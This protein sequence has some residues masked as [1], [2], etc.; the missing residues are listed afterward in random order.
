MLFF[1]PRNCLNKTIW[2]KNSFEQHI[3]TS[4]PAQC[5]TRDGREARKTTSPQKGDTH[6]TC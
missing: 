4:F 2:R 1:L 3:S 6:D 5:S